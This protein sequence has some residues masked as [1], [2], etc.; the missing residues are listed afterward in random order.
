MPEPRTPATPRISP[1]RRSNETFSSSPGFEIPTARKAIPSAGTALARLAVIFG[2]PLPT[3]DQFV[4]RRLV[5]AGRRALIDD[6]AVLEGDELV[7]GR[8]DVGKS[9]RDEHEGRARPPPRYALEQLHGLLVGERA[10]RLVEQDDRLDRVDPAQ[11]EGLGD[12]DELSLAEGQR[13][14]QGAW[15]HVDVQVVQHRFRLSDHRALAQ[16]AR[17]C[18]ELAFAA[19]K[20][21]LVHGD[22][23]D[24]SLL[25]EDRRNPVL[26]RLGRMTEADWMSVDGERA[27]NRDGPNR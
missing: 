18:E 11:R 15:I 25:L 2:V 13:S 26:R 23:G 8:E 17:A 22:C 5:D 14:R 21:V 3:D 1:F 16:K 12:L 9:M 6:A 7:A 4:Q 20:D 27:R 24:Q 19:E 10:R